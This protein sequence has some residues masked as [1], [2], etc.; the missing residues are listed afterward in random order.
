MVQDSDRTRASRREVVGALGRQRV[1]PE[2]PIVGLAA[3][4]VLV[5]G[6]VVDQQQE[7]GSGQTLDQAVEQRLG[8]GVDPVQ[9]LEQHQKRLHL[10]L[11]EQQTL[12]AI[13]RPLPPLRG[14]EPLPRGILDWDVQQREQRRE[15]GLQARSSDSSLPV[16]F[17]RIFRVLVPPLDLE[18]HLEQVD[19]GQVGGRLAV[20]HRATFQDR[21]SPAVRWEWVNSQ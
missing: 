17:S 2:L 12:H 15:G 20:G 18:I 6:T 19:N 21:A 10:A 9:V 14:I 8:L 5:L 16:T 1:D 4:A 13:Q 11:P 3:P 7:P